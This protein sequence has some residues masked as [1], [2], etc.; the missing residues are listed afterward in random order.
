[1]ITHLCPSHGV[2]FRYSYNFAAKGRIALINTSYTETK[3]KQQQNTI[4]KWKQKQHNK[5][6]TTFSGR[7]EIRGTTKETIIIIEW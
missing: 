3:Q 7:K 5:K 6:V 1:M 4:Q 2:M